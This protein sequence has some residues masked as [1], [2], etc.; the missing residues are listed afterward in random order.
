[1]NIAEANLEK[2]IPVDASPLIRESRSVEPLAFAEKGGFTVSLSPYDVP[3]AMRGRTDENG[4]CFIIEFKYLTP[5]EPMAEAETGT[6]LVKIYLGKNS[7]R[8]YSIRACTHEGEHNVFSVQLKSNVQKA[9]ENLEQNATSDF[10][11]RQ[12]VKVIEDLTQIIYARAHAVTKSAATA[13]P[14]LVK[15][16]GSPNTD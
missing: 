11:P 1:M 10:G 9:L 15:P 12:R 3:E 5:S 14:T 13:N 2:W 16:S 8:I 6:D 4:R 7:G